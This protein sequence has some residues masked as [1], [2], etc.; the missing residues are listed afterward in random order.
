MT[1]G[2]D[3]T[4]VVLVMVDM[5]GIIVKFYLRAALTI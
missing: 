1:S 5:Y 2:K 3:N 4:V